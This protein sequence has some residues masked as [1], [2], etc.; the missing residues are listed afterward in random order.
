M[1]TLLAK[2]ALDPEALTMCSKELW[3]AMEP[4]ERRGLRTAHVRLR[5]YWE[6]YG[7]LLHD[8]ED[9]TQSQLAATLPDMTIELRNVWKQYLKRAER[10]KRHPAPDW[11]GIDA[12]AGCS[13][14]HDIAPDLDLACLDGN[15][16]SSF[17]LSEEDSAAT[18]TLEEDCTLELCRF[19]DLDQAECFKN[20]AAAAQRNIPGGTDVAAVWNDWFSPLAHFSQRVTVVDRYGGKDGSSINGLRRLL[21]QLDGDVVAARDRNVTLYLGYAADS[22]TTPIVDTIVEIKGELTR[23]G[24]KGIRIYLCSDSVFERTSHDR[25]L[26]FGPLAC[27]LGTGVSILSGRMTYRSSTYSL[28]PVTP[29]HEDILR[30]LRTAKHKDYP[31]DL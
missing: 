21:V 20:T 23:G 24:V 18:V 27:E 2:F 26:C 30:A 28:K 4:A 12:A 15:S 8:G 22:E 29:F 3:A 16:A 1:S 13:S 7:V 11:Q 14:L 6:Q 9:I 5:S 10:F 19:A 31:Q 17:G 25:F